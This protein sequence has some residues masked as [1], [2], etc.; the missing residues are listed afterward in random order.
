MSF[1]GAAWNSVP[2]INSK[3]NGQ[4]YMVPIKVV[5]AQVQVVAG[6]NTVLEVL[7]GESTCP[8]QGSVQASQ[9]TAANCPLKSGGKREL[10]KVSI[11]EKLWEHFE[12]IEKIRDVKADEKFEIKLNECTHCKLFLSFLFIFDN[13]YPFFL[14]LTCI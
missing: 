12:Q 10:Y 14:N 1:Q 2:E 5:K 6:T 3:N 7:V 11:W 8:R 4:N 9:V 13:K